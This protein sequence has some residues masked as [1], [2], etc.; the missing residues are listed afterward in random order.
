MSFLLKIK[1]KCLVFPSATFLYWYHVTE[2]SGTALFN[3]NYLIFSINSEW[4]EK[5]KTAAW[6]H[7]GNHAIAPYV[8]ALWSRSKLLA[9]SWTKNLNIYDW[10]KLD[11]F[12]QTVLL[13]IFMHDGF[14]AT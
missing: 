9:D 5:E 11:F 8:P 6:K 3:G 14:Q 7:R 2:I 12:V 10:K 4:E 1:K 13:Y